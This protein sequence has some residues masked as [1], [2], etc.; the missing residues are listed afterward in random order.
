MI[1]NIKF[2]DEFYND[3]VE[4]WN[5]IIQYS[6][7]VVHGKIKACKKHIWACARFLKDI[8]KSINDPDYEFYFDV[9]E[10]NQFNEWASLFKHRV[11]VLKGKNIELVDWQLFMSA[12]IFCWKNKK[13]GYRRIKKVYIQVAR[14]NAKS[15]FLAIISSYHCF[16]EDEQAEVYITG[17]TSKGSKIV[18]KEIEFQ[19][20]GVEE[21]KNKFKSSYGKI[22]HLK[23]G[24]EIIPL[25]REAKENGDG[26]NPSLG[27]ADEYHQHKTSEIYDS[28]ESGMGARPQP[29]MVIITTSGFRLDYPCFKEYLYVSK[30]LNPDH[31]I[32]NEEYFI[33]ICEIDPEDN[34][35]DE[36][37]WI[38]ANPIACTYEEGINKIRSDL[39]TAQDAP[40]KMRTF[41]TKRMNRWVDMKEDG[42]MNMMKWNKCE[43]VFDLSKFI[44]M[45]CVLGVDLSTKLDLTSIAFEF[46]IDGKYYGYQHSFMPEE[47]YRIRMNENKFPFNVW[48]DQG[49]LTITEGSVIDY[50]YVKKYILD[51]IEEFNINILEI[52]YDPYNATQF[53]NDMRDLGFID[54]EIRQG[55]FTL[56]EPTKDLR[57]KVYEENFLHCG[58]GLFSWAMGNAVSKQNAQEFVMLDKSKS[59]EKIDPSVAMINAHCRGMKILGDGLNDI[60]ISPN[61]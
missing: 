61:I 52:C 55:V 57:D 11:G 20:K 28:I 33:M 40:E 45:D 7:D 3:E 8:D 19:L 4:L 6:Y 21:F 35:N 41:L 38:K 60:M 37:N 18:F 30:I 47:Q 23:S 48:R 49:Y 43:R 59:S 10:L 56:N 9:E 53:M 34:I 25:S 29:L 2:S 12:N 31:Q 27:I 17:W 58:D 42:Y 13:N 15:Q 5:R 14:K 46:K 51:T 16:L 1:N 32:E 54:V 36:E 44:G 50:N 22:T 39:K 26:T 24:G